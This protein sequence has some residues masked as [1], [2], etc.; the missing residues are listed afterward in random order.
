MRHGFK[1]I[2]GSA[3]DK[4]TAREER[5]FCSSPSSSNHDELLT[6]GC[7]AVVSVIPAQE[8]REKR[9][10]HMS[11]YQMQLQCVG[12]EFDLRR[13]GREGALEQW[14]LRASSCYGCNRIHRPKWNTLHP[15]TVASASGNW[16]LVSAFKMVMT[17]HKPSPGQWPGFFSGRQAKKFA[18]LIFNAYD[19]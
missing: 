16:I 2:A 9:Y 13:D 4:G 19:I 17:D 15:S 6:T 11:S 14:D 18:V 1:S 5:A 7:V 3:G 12:I 8:M 10:S